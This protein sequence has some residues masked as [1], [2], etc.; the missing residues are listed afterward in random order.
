MNKF[1]E[2]INNDNLNYYINLFENLNESDM[3]KIN[4]L[5]IQT[6][7]NPIKALAKISKSRGSNNIQTLNTHYN[8]A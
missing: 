1:N 2:P 6:L 3:F 5:H 7:P 4:L 8:I